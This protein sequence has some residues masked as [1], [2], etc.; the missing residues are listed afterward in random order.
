M[1]TL[2]LPTTDA[3]PTPPLASGGNPEERA[4]LLLWLAGL[5][6]APQTAASLEAHRQ[7]AGA[8]LLSELAADRDLGPGARA[9]SD[10]LADDVS[11]ADLARRLEM[12]FGLDFLGIA[13]PATAAPYESA[14]RCGGRLFQAPVGEMDRLLAAHDLSVALPGEPSDHLA[15]EVALLAH[16]VA[17]GHPDRQALADRLALW[18][19]DFRDRVIAI[20][21]TG[22]YAGAAHTLTAAIRREGTTRDPE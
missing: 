14:H 8:A 6:A 18:V 10:A 12:D 16:L 2:V 22:F 4:G 7:G 13:G 21:D 19:P 9:M 17:S 11:A 20:D 15:I 3:L 5:F 1:T